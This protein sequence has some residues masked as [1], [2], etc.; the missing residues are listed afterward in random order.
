[1]IKMIVI[2]QFSLPELT[3]YEKSKLLRYAQQLL[4]A[5][6]QMITPEGRNIIHYTLG[7]N[8]RHQHMDHYPKGDRIDYDTG[9][10]YF[11][12]CHRENFETEEHGHFHCFLRYKYISK[13]IRPTPLP[14]WDKNSDNP[15][16]HIVAIAMNRYGEPIRLFSINRWISNEIWYDAKHTL[17]FIK[18]FKMKKND[19]SYWQILDRWIEG[20]IH[21]FAPQI[22]W[23]NKVR[24]MTI[25]H[26]KTIYADD[27]IYEDPR[28]DLLSEI[29]INLNQQI[30]W[31]LELD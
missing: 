9:A 2:P 23:I 25:S 19:S 3:K 16:T 5:Q 30:R 29:P 12:H 24:D 31:V 26:Y 6:Q 20:M 28:L 18:K 27:N 15:M 4:E 11:Y 14:D 13:K 1:M 10:Q 7:N 22:Q 17:S 8:S 21:L